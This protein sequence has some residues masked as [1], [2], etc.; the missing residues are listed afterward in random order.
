MNWDTPIARPQHVRALLA[1]AGMDRGALGRLERPAG[2]YGERNRRPGRA[3]RGGPHFLEA[4]AGLLRDR[5]SSRDLAHAALAGP[6]RGGGVALGELDGVEALLH[7][8]VDVFCGD[9]LAEAN[10]RFAV[11]GR[12]STVHSQSTV[13][14]DSVSTVDC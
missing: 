8:E 6:H 1:L 3:G 5:P 13:P 10:E 12:R 2:Q 14:V 7:A 11:H 9:V 4:L